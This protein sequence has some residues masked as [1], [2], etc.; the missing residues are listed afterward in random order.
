MRHICVLKFLGHIGLSHM[1]PSVFPFAICYSSIGRRQNHAPVLL[2]F[3]FRFRR[4]YACRRLQNRW[5]PNKRVKNASNF[6]VKMEKTLA[7]IVEEL[8]QELSSQFLLSNDKTTK[9]ALGLMHDHL[10]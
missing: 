1:T 8:L 6:T 5:P 10:T 3:F 9:L 2:R 7:Y 4:A